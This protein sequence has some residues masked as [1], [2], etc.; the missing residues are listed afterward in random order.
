[1][2][3]IISAV[4]G[5][6]LLKRQAIAVDSAFFASDYPFGN[7]VL[8]HLEPGQGDGAQLVGG[9]YV[10]T[11]EDAAV[12]PGLWRK[13]RRAQR[14]DELA[15]ALTRFADPYA[16][17]KPEDR[18][19]DAWI[20]LESL[21]LPEEYVSDMKPTIALAM[22]NYLGTTAAERR[23]IYAFVVSAHKMRSDIV[24]GRRG[25][26]PQ[27][28]HE[29]S[30]KM[31]DFVRRVLRQRIEEYSDDARPAAPAAVAITDAA[32]VPDVSAEPVTGS[33]QPTPG[34]PTDPD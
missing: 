29:T 2:A 22:S 32:A 28:L 24:H 26:D 5:L 30:A 25:I 9:D 13:A 18:L 14:D 4:S 34:S 33:L 27:D 20:V 3:H 11:E 23:S 16:R 6:R 7:T 10:L 17:R 15:I 12:L 19:V 31:G 8:S 21:F 1:V